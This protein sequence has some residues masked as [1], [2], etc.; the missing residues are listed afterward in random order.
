[1]GAA[2]KWWLGMS[3]VR[4]ENLKQESKQ[5]MNPDFTNDFVMQT[6]RELEN[7][8]VRLKNIEH[9]ITQIETMTVAIERLATNMEHMVAEQNE[10]GERLQKL[11]L[12]DGQMWQKVLSYTITAIVSIALGFIARSIGIQ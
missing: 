5:T 2:F 3:Q 12:K 4:K 1:M 8:N 11:E 9:I 10:Q 7:L 6:N